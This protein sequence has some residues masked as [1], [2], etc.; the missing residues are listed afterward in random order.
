MAEPGKM[1]MRIRRG[2]SYAAVAT[3]T[4][5][6][7]AVPVDLAGATV[8]AQIR[9]D[10]D[11]SAI[12]ATIAATVTNAAGGVITL[13]LTP[14]QT[15]ALTPGVAVWDLQVSLSPTDVHTI[16]AGPV[17]VERDVTR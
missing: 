16:L 15:A 5:G 4:R 8:A 1:T 17:I 10:A 12:L 3:W 13:A 2:D 9:A 14:V 7:P 11:S 6:A